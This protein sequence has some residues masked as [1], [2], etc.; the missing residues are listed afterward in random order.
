MRAS[1]SMGCSRPVHVFLARHRLILKAASTGVACSGD[2]P[3]G[4]DCGC[5][6]YNNHPTLLSR[7][8]SPRVFYAKH[9]GGTTGQLALVVV[10]VFRLELVSVQ[11]RMQMWKPHRLVAVAWQAYVS[12]REYK[13]ALH[14]S[15]EIS[16]IYGVAS[17]DSGENP[18]VSAGAIGGTGGCL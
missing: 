4:Y 7:L 1:N 16:I 15:A 17:C 11:V 5:L 14:V 9:A 6:V 18:T 2:V 10:M 3:K 8:V 13:R 12:R